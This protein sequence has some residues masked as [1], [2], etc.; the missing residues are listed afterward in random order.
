M[1][2]HLGDILGVLVSKLVLHEEVSQ[3]VVMTFGVRRYL[4]RFLHARAQSVEIARRHAWSMQI[5]LRLKGPRDDA[6]LLYPR[7]SACV[8]SKVQQ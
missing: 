2:I 3:R 8:M 7:C 4:D 5:F 1:A 6:A